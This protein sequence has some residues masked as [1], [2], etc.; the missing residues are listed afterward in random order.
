MGAKWKK[1]GLNRQVIINFKNSPI[2]LTRS[3][4][5]VADSSILLMGRFG[6]EYSVGFIRISVGLYFC[7][8]ITVRWTCSRIVLGGREPDGL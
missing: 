3:V 4:G 8:W 1:K 5:N 2:L 7:I 6:F